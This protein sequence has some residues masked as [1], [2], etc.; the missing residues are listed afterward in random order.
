MTHARDDA[1]IRVGLN[2]YLDDASRT[3][4]IAQIG[5]DATRNHPFRVELGWSPSGADTRVDAD[6][7][8][9]RSAEDL[10][11][12]SVVLASLS[13]EVERRSRDV[14]KELLHHQFDRIVEFDPAVLDQTDPLPLW[15][16]MTD[17]DK[18]IL[19][20]YLSGREVEAGFDP[21][22]PI[23]YSAEPLS[24]LDPQ[25]AHEHAMFI[26]EAC[27]V[28][29]TLSMPEYNRLLGLARGDR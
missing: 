27:R 23:R 14:E 5:A 15:A 19:L 6:L 9:A 11:E 2:L 20:D 21:D 3:A 8:G 26:V 13:V 1:Q 17:L 16:G 18:G 4:A 25:V 12:L 29:E 10:K 7:I 22:A 28:P 24:D